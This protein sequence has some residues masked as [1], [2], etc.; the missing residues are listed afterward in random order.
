MH[1]LR[2]PLEQAEVSA[3]QPD[4][5]PDPETE[6]F[7]TSL[8]IDVDDIATRTFYQG[9]VQQTAA[10]APLQLFYVL[11]GH[12]TY[13]NSTG[14]RALKRGTLLVAL[15]VPDLR[16][17]VGAANDTD[18]QACV[19]GIPHVDIPRSGQAPGDSRLTL[20]CI[21]LSV[22]SVAELRLFEQLDSALIDHDGGSH[23]WQTVE[24]LLGEVERQRI[25]ARSIIQSLTKNLVLLAMREHL[26]KMQ[27][28]NPL[29]LLLSEPRIAR[30]VNAITKNPDQRHTMSSL[31]QLAAMSPQALSRRFEAIFAM[32]P[33]DFVLH[34]RLTKAATLLRATDLPV[35]TIAGKVGFASRSH[36]SRLFSKFSGCDPTA[37]RLEQR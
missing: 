26:S 10:R 33:N 32:A 21:D 3:W 25:G 35:K 19:D 14:T 36:F 12:G 2:S 6:A 13:S 16:I 4:A 24:L 5:L 30:V 15:N 9:E 27:S 22:T 7:L 28:D 37:Y 31:A 1:M 29:R 20:A 17:S 8:C 11:D 34:V 23:M 18:S